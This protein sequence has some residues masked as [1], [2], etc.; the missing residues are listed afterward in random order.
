MTLS[1]ETM[2]AALVAL[3]LCLTS[4]LANAGDLDVVINGKSHHVN[5]QYDWNEKN[6]GLG[7]EYEMNSS[8]RWIKTLSANAFLDS[9]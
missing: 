1:K 4:V 8:T 2:S 9:L 6:F 5:S 7:L 3:L